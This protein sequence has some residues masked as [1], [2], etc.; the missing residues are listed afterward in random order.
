MIL[1]S[2]LHSKLAVY[3]ISKECR[4]MIY[5]TLKLDSDFG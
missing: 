1:F 3:N 2:L 4:E 5:V